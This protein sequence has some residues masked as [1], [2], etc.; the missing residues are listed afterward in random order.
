MRFNDRTM[1]RKD[2]QRRG[3]KRM[4]VRNDFASRCN[5]ENTSRFARILPRYPPEYFYPR[6][7]VRRDGNMTARVSREAEQLTTDVCNGG[8]RISNKMAPVL[9]Y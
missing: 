8:R 2:N 3:I 5:A 7:N 9:T 1:T 4:T 6:C